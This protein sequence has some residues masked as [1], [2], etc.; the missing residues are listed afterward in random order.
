MRRHLFV[1]GIAALWAACQ[2]QLFTIHVEESAETL[3]EQGTLLED[4]VG[5]LGFSDF[6]EMDL[7]QS[8]ELQNQGVEPGDIQEVRFELLELEALEPEGADL[9]FLSAMDVY[10]EAPG[11]DAVL[12]ASQDAFPEGQAL[13]PFDL[14][15]V[16][17]TDY[18]VS[19]SMTIRTEVT[20]HR[21]DEDTLVEARFDVAV[22]V[23][24]QGA[25]NNL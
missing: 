21:P 19:Q 25:C 17:L 18:V 15:D 13:V 9:S 6:L 3:V 8:T 20:G 1:M 14:E 23:T 12:I 2:A 10:V 24:G 16:D 7:T 5:E 4:L 11:L 22:G